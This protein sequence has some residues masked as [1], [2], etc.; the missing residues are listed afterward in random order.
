MSYTIKENGD[1]LTETNEGVIL[2]VDCSFEKVNDWIHGIDVHFEELQALCLGMANENDNLKQQ[3]AESQ[4]SNERLRGAIDLLRTL[5]PSTHANQGS[6]YGEVCIA[7]AEVNRAVS[8]TPKQS[9]AHIKAE[10]VE[11]YGKAIVGWV[12]GNP[13][14][15]PEKYANQLREGE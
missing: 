1:V 7:W 12:H 2:P 6:D 9:L 10:A 4:A 14:P 11:D 8:E 3:L 13:I 5:N 15:K